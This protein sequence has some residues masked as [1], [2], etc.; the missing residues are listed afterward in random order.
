MHELTCKEPTHV[1]W[2]GQEQGREWNSPGSEWSAHCILVRECHSSHLLHR[3]SLHLG[4]MTTLIPLPATMV[5][6]KSWHK[7]G[8]WEIKF[9]RRWLLP[10]NFPFCWKEESQIEQRIEWYDKRLLDPCPAGGGTVPISSFLAKDV[11]IFLFFVWAS[12]VPPFTS[13]QH[14]IVGMP[15]GFEI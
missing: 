7:E 13:C 5:I 1:P 9:C 10:L 11:F 12:L 3:W 8:I 4:L 6:E 14:Y 15:S 2:A